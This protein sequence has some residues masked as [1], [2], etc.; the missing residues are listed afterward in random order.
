MN[1]GR[2][3]ELGKHADLIA[4]DGLYAQLYRTQFKQQS[5]Q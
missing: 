5:N 3:V 2:I 1:R 4:L